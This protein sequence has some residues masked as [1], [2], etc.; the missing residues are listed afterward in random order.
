MRRAIIIGAKGQDGR[1]LT[2]L[3]EQSGVSVRAV[4]RESLDLLD[5]EAVRGLLRTEKPAELYYLAA[6]H[7]SSEEK[8]GNDEA[9][10]FRRSM[11]IHVLG[12]IEVLEAIRLISPATRLFYAA[13]SRIF[14]A[15]TIAPQSEVT[16]AVPRCAYGI[17]KLTGVN[18]CRAYRSQHGVYA[19]TGILYNHESPLRQE[20]FVSQKIVQA[21]HR[22]ARNG[23]GQLLLGDLSA[24]ID[25]GYAPD[26]V[27]A[28]RRILA[29]PSSDDF[30][31]AT[32]ETHTVQ[33]FVEIA[34]ARLGLDWRKHVSESPALVPKRGAVIVGDTTKLRQN[35]G[36]APSVTF[37]Q[38]VELLVDAQK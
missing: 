26:F 38:M 10:L 35:T 1:L 18:C 25:W 34:F 11:E 13:S 19:S 29:L 23:S 37:R 14:G 12:L 32:G 28:M 31:I 33:E 17:S 21:A 5:R 15:T 30:V 36:W 27:E 16:P 9:D 4:T 24:T 6:Y 7:H 20:K 22:I 3:L 2:N 8:T